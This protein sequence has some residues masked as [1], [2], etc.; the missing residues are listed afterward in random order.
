MPVGKHREKENL[1]ERCYIYQRIGNKAE[2]VKLSMKYSDLCSVLAGST[3]ELVNF[4]KHIDFDLRSVLVCVNSDDLKLILSGLGEGFGAKE[5]NV[6]GVLEIVKV[7]LQKPK[8][9]RVILRRSN[10]LVSGKL[11]ER[12]KEND[13]G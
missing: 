1:K 4:L 7:A 10:R 2:I 12:K 6:S 9:E 5:T 13:D 3:S 8:R 11:I